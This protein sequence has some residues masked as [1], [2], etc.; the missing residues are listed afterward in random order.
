MIDLDALEHFID[1][2]EAGRDQ[3]SS[4]GEKAARELLRAVLDHAQALDPRANK[5]L[6]EFIQ[7]L[8]HKPETARG[9]V[10]DALPA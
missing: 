3:G 1:L 7:L 9:F 8:K 4:S 6:C 2:V 5:G 10:S